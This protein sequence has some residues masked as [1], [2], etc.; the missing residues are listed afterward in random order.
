[1]PLPPV[2]QRI[3]VISAEQAAGFQ[4]F[5]EQLRQNA[6]GYQFSCTFFP[7][8]MQGNQVE[9]EIV[10]QL[11]RIRN[12]AGRYDAV[13]IIRAAAPGSTWPGLTVF[14]FAGRSPRFRFRCLPASGTTSTRPSPTSSP[15]PP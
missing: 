13:A 5:Q 10:A 15:I 9:T 8:A 6:Y 7:A 4:D 1:M 11:G 14:P 3:A 2:L 12:Q